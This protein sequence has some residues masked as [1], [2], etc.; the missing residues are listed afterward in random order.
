VGGVYNAELNAMPAYAVDVTNKTFSAVTD[1]GLWEYAYDGHIAAIISAGSEQ[2]ANTIIKRHEQACEMFV[3]RHQFMH[4]TQAQ[5]AGN[6]FSIR[7]LAF[8]DAAF[9]GAEEVPAET[10]KYVWV[11]GFRISLVWI[12]SEEGSN[13]HA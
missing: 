1:S 5:V 2:A 13:D 11:A 8:A 10:N 9:S 6:D 3:K 4:Q 12:L 7:T